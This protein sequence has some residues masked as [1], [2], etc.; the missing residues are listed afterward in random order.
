MQETKE[1]RVWSLGQADPLEKGMVN[2]SSILA[3]RI[4]WTEEPTVHRVEKSQT[5]LQRL[6][7]NA[8]LFVP[9]DFLLCTSDIFIILYGTDN[10]SWNESN[11]ELV[12]IQGLERIPQF[13]KSKKSYKYL[14]CIV[15]ISTVGLWRQIIKIDLAVG[16]ECLQPAP[17]D[18]F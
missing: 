5:Q 2:H 18:A 12:G 10:D 4:A 14:I 13:A 9:F 7:M 1:T 11:L 8:H 15:L 3:W 16:T 6:S 17:L